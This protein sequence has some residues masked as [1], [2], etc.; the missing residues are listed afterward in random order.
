MKRR[1]RCLNCKDLFR[2]RPQCKSQCY[3]SEP[4][5][6]KE[7]KK[8]S[9]QRWCDKNPEYF[10]GQSARVQQWREENPGYWRNKNGRKSVKKSKPLQEVSNP[11][12]IEGEN[13]SSILANNALQEV[14][15]AQLTVI[16][17]LMSNLT[18]EPLQ[19]T[20][21]SQ[22]HK[23]QNKGSEILGIR[24]GIALTEITR[25]YQYEEKDHTRAGSD[26]PVTRVL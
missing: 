19:E 7:S 10:K 21:D 3:C 15:I 23:L 13:D 14:C 18:Q 20:L 16:Y 1:K 9:Q 22:L 25:R 24:S 2:P 17:G 8:A 26:P 6:Q 12:S 11:Q 4:S 5:C